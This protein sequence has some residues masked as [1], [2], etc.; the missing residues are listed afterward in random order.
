MLRLHA[1]LEEIDD[2]V[3]N[4]LDDLGFPTLP[5]HGSNHWGL[6][7]DAFPPNLSGAKDIASNDPKGKGKA[8]AK[9]E[10]RAD[11]DFFWESAPDSTPLLH[12][13]LSAKLTLATSLVAANQAPRPRSSSYNPALPLRT[14]KTDLLLRLVTGTSMTV[15]AGG[16][17]I[18]GKVPKSTD[19]ARP[20][21]LAIIFQAHFLLWAGKSMIKGPAALLRFTLADVLNGY[22]ESDAPF[23]FIDGLKT[24]S[25][26]ELDFE[27][28]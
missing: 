15:P 16:I 4:V 11:W 21:F 28:S 1:K 27:K 7:R 6:L 19:L 26:T 22:C 17:S 20:Y 2:Y 10:D 25:V 5:E 8:K 24:P 9:K 12:A 14:H 23:V 18:D 3:V 13:Q